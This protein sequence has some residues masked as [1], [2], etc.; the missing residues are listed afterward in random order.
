MYVSL[1]LGADE[2]RD[3]DFEY[4]S[5]EE[6]TPGFH[7]R[8]LFAFFFFLFLSAIAYCKP[9]NGTGAVP[10]SPKVID[11][12]LSPL[13]PRAEWAGPYDTSAHVCLVCCKDG[14]AG[15]AGVERA[16]LKRSPAGRYT[17]S[18]RWWSSFQTNSTTVKT[19]VKNQRSST[20]S[21]EPPPRKIRMGDR[22]TLFV[23]GNPE[24]ASPCSCFET[25]AGGVIGNPIDRRG[26]RNLLF[27]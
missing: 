12:G 20:I 8:R 26:V 5:M 18:C 21:F 13:S 2:T 15:P 6:L 16:R 27:I 14:S 24:R 23:R 3:G 22:P 11:G 19:L 17:Y 25:E 4:R 9:P 10:S 1:H 7:R